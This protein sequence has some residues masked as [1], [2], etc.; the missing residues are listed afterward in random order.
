MC[1]WLL[2]GCG[3]CSWCSCPLFFSSLCW[4]V[5]WDVGLWWWCQSANFQPLRGNEKR[6]R[7]SWI[8]WRWTFSNPI[9]LSVFVCVRNHRMRFS[10]RE[11]IAGDTPKYYIMVEG[12]LVLLVFINVSYTNCIRQVGSQKDP[13]QV[14]Q[15]MLMMQVPNPVRWLCQCMVTWWFAM[16]CTDKS[17]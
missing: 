13:R 3:Y 2:V 12:L 14:W 5:R 15:W 6:A 16:I 9:Y 10:P 1:L 7:Q 17:K 8:A 11:P 4:F